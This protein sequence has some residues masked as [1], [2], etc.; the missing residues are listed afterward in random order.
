MPGSV[1]PYTAT[2][3][4]GQVVTINGGQGITDNPTDVVSGRVTKNEVAQ[5]VPTAPDLVDPTYTQGM[6]LNVLQNNNSEAPNPTVKVG[7]KKDYVRTFEH[8]EEGKVK[9]IWRPFKEALEAAQIVPETHGGL[10]AVQPQTSGGYPEGVYY[11]VRIFETDGTGSGALGT[12]TVDANGVVTNIE[13]T[14]FGDGFTLNNT[15]SILT[16]DI[17]PDNVDTGILRLLAI[18]EH[19][20]GYFT[21]PSIG[22]VATVSTIDQGDGYAQPTHSA[23]GQYFY[24]NVRVVSTTQSM[25]AL[26]N[27][28]IS[29]G[30]SY[31]EQVEITFGGQ[32]FEVGQ[33]CYFFNQTADMFPSNPSRQWVGSV[34][35]IASVGVTQVYMNVPL[36]GDD[37]GTGAEGT[38]QVGNTG[39]VQT[40]TLTAFGDNY[41]VNEKVRIGD[42]PEM[43]NGSGFV[44]VVNFVMA[45]EVSVVPVAPFEGIVISIH[46]KSLTTRALNLFT[47][48]AT[49]QTQTAPSLP[50]EYP[51]PV[52]LNTQEDYNQW[53]YDVVSQL[54]SSGGG[55]ESSGNMHLVA[56]E[57]DVIHTEDNDSTGPGGGSIQIGE[58]IPGGYAPIEMFVTANDVGN[59]LNPTLTMR[60][61]NTGGS[62]THLRNTTITPTY[63]QMQSADKEVNMNN[64]QLIIR[65]Q[66]YNVLLNT[67]GLYCTRTH[68]AP[69]HNGKMF[70]T[71]SGITVEHPSVNNGNT[72]SLSNAQLFELRQVVNDGIDSTPLAAVKQRIEDLE[73]AV[74]SLTGGS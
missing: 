10:G 30:G 64:Q 17:V 14:T 50:A 22:P 69:L 46:P 7:V 63:L 36:E 62:G 67:N 48:S 60:Q 37:G 29:S 56:N 16:S 31:V 26:A 9:C 6:I 51:Q 28:Y 13:V 12:V 55:G 25:Q 35:S 52:D 15:V 11:N 49:S 57:I 1:P 43:V 27:V 8:V 21:Q 70:Y 41:T 4:S 33:H 73:A 47:P 23:G 2:S 71:W 66:H 61:W 19:G 53:I 5:W 34:E 40:V 45:Q 59:P 54:I 58:N 38:L 24:P 74:A 32:L 39:E 3:S 18:E 68:G 42:Y 72:F 20:T 44:C 65:N